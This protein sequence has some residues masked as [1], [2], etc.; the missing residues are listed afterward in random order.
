M[1]ILKILIVNLI[2][3]FLFILIIEV[4]F[5]NW[6]SNN[7][8]WQEIFKLNVILNK[9]IQY[10]I[11][12]L[13]K[14][15]SNIINYTRNEYGLRQICG[16]NKNIDILTIGGSTTDQ[17]FIDDIDTFQFKLQ[18]KLEKYLNK[19]ICVSNAG[20]DGH[21]TF[22][23]LDSF[24]NWFPNIP[25][26]NPKHIIL[27]VGINDAGIR[28]NP[29]GFDYNPVKGFN[30]NNF[31]QKTKWYLSQRSAIYNLIR[32]Y[33]KVFANKFFLKNQKY[34]VY[35]KIDFTDDIYTEQYT[36]QN[37]EQLI[38]DNTNKFRSRFDLLLDFIN[39]MGAK[40]ICVTQP[41]LK[42]KKIGEAERGIK[43]AF[44]FNYQ[45]YNGLDFDLSLKKI[46]IVI[47]ELCIRKN[48]IFI[49]YTD[50]KLDNEN[51]YDFIHMT[52][53][54]NSKL[55]KKLFDFYVKFNLVDDFK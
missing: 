43:E 51:F 26:L 12:H 28:L 31:K 53:D 11:E 20:V 18:N 54:G 29:R 41:H 50:T 38:F 35:R 13:Y 19:K 4:I 30:I 27:F 10:N 2:I 45:I 32:N 14:N 25:N 37:I 5:G 7:D 44:P 17:R 16:R 1:K 34:Q 46:N 55:A 3:F 48:G 42:V 23:H 33:Y 36:S 52:P 22:G 8:K 9:K 39:D 40:P 47:K 21:S 49:N 15:P 24:K 6:F